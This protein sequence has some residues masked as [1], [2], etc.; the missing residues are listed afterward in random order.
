MEIREKMIHTIAS[1]AAEG[2]LY[3][4]SATP[5]PGLV[6]RNNSGAHKDM[7]YFTFL[8]SAASLHSCFDDMARIGIKYAKHAPKEMLPALQKCGMEAEKKMFLATGG[9][10]THKGMIFS[11]GLLSACAGWR[12]ERK[13]GL[14]IKENHRNPENTA[15]KPGEAICLLAGKV[16]EGICERDYG[17]LSYKKVLTK[18]EKMYLQY[19]CTG[20]RGEAESG[21]RTVRQVS[22]PVYERLRKQDISVNDALVHTLLS[23]IANTED[24][25]ILSR[26]NKDVA[27]YAQKEAKKVLDTGGVFTEKGRERVQKLDDDFIE[28]YI[29]PGGCADLLAVTHFLYVL[30]QEEKKRRSAYDVSDNRTVIFSIGNSD[31]IREKY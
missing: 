29:S 8:S 30:E 31:R 3:E 20:I 9:V 16:C 23:L 5:K 21:Y 10:N 26:H 7:D 18:G 19:G 14:G 25:N 17:T 22:Y 1:A 27:E 6:D 12:W 15:L 11:M 28:R 13:Y 2:I 24:T 4:V